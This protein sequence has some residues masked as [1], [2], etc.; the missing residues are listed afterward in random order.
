MKVSFTSIVCFFILQAS[1]IA[2][3][4]VRR[5]AG[6]ASRWAARTLAPMQAGSAA[7][8]VATR[9]AAGGERRRA[10]GAR[11]R[12]WREEEFAPGTRAHAWRR[13]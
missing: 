11:R 5:Q 8:G 4:S 10:A 1:R 13:A 9:R 7:S 6:F 12:G 3:L 2:A